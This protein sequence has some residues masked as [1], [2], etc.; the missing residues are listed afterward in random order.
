MKNAKSY[1]VQRMENVRFGG[2]TF[3]PDKELLEQTRRDG[4]FEYPKI[5]GVKLHCDSSIA[6]YLYEHQKT[7]KFKIERQDD[8]SLIIILKPSFEHEIIRWVLG[9]GGHIEVLHPESL[10]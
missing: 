7:K 3:E 9:E 2:D 5:E 4:L 1:A 8:G 6:F 10:R